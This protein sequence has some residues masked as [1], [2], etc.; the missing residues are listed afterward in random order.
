MNL[1]GIFDI[2]I[3]NLET[4]ICLEEINSSN[5]REVKVNIPKIMTNNDIND[6]LYNSK[7]VVPFSILANE[8]ETFP[9]TNTSLSIK[10]Y[11]TIPLSDNFP[12]DIIIK[13]GDIVNILVLNKNI[14]NMKIINI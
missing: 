5:T 11:I 2:E 12:K 3:E 7:L 9:K 6:K 8:S 1:D 13:K 4:G 10:N 14:K